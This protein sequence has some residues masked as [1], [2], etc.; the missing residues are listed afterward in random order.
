MELSKMV[1]NVKFGL[2]DKDIHKQIFNFKNQIQKEF[3]MVLR[4]AIKIDSKKQRRVQCS[5]SKI[6][7]LLEKFPN[8]ILNRSCDN[9]VRGFI[10]CNKIYSLPR[11]R[12]MKII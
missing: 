1:K 3:D 6:S 5:I 7:L 9:I 11:I 4:I 10:I 8:C 12:H 2:I